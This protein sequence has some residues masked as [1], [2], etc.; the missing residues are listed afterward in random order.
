[1]TRTLPLVALL[2]CG[3]TAPTG[4]TAPTAS[5]SSPACTAVWDVP[6]RS[7]ASQTCYGYSTQTGTSVPQCYDCAV[8]GP[9]QTVYREADTIDIT[10]DP[11][12]CQDGT[13]TQNGQTIA[14]YDE[15][16][17]TLT[18]FTS[19]DSRTFVPDELGVCPVF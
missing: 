2:A 15:A 6:F 16:T 13:F 7:E 17:G 9:D 12:T 11:V 18:W 4:D 3:G 10:E 1:M 8:I 19:G 14:T 5:G